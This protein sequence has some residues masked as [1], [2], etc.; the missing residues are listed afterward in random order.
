MTRTHLIAMPLVGAEQVAEK[1]FL[2]F[3]GLVVFASVVVL[4]VSLAGRTPHVVVCKN[5]TVQSSS[6]AAQIQHRDKD[7]AEWVAPAATFSLLSLIEPSV[8]HASTEEFLVYPH[9]DSL[10]N[11]PPPIS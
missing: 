8:V 11:R 7:G 2:S 9:Y 1:R 10:Y 4:I 5:A 6:A 3:R